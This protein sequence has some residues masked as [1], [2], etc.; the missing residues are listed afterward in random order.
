MNTTEKV[1]RNGDKYRILL[2]EDHPVFRKGLKALVEQEEN[3]SVCGE[4]DSVSTALHLINSANPD[5][6]VVDIALKG[7]NGLDLIPEMTSMKPDL[8]ILVVSMFDETTYVRRAL[9][10]GARGYIVKNESTETVIAAIQAILRGEMAISEPHRTRILE[11]QFSSQTSDPRSNPQALLTNRELEIFQLI[12][13]GKATRE[14]SGHLKLSTKTIGTYRERLKDK[15]GLKH[16]A[17]LAKYAV[18]YVQKQHF[19]G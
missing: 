13:Q 10:T 15:L 4:A 3:L 12:G 17:E 6:A 14:I 2:I 1:T 18:Q 11:S 7:R 9:Q 16:A 19:N 5:L 8:L